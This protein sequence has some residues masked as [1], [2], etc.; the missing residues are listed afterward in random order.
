MTENDFDR[1]ARL[2]LEDGPTELS[3]RVLQAA[4]DEIHVTKQRRAWWPAR[5]FRQMNTPI[6]IAVAAAAVVLIALVGVN[7]MGRNGG[8]VGGPPASPT[9]SPTTAPPSASPTPA[10]TVAQGSAPSS[11]QPGTYVAADP[12]LVQVTFTVPAGW[13]GNIGGPFLVN[14]DRPDGKGQ[15]SFSISPALYADPCQSDRLQTQQPGPAVADLATA[16]ANLPGLQATTPTDVS[17]GGY[18]G[19]QLT[20]TAPASGSGCTPGPDGYA[21]WQLPLGAVNNLTPGGSDRVWILDVNGQRLVIDSQV[22]PSQTAAEVQGVLDSIRLAPLA[23][24]PSP[25]TSAG[26]SP[27]ASPR[28][29]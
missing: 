16:L 14:L 27:S 17:L 3:D 6:R 12:F 26:V 28:G 20:L 8:G 23:P 19:K 4:L 13:E 10:P 11:L 2:W 1:T 15:V 21:L 9:A 25:S 7:L 24:S 22:P 18:Q 5:R 29:S